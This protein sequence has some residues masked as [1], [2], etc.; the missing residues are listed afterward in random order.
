MSGSDKR[1]DQG[2]RARG[3]STIDGFI[4]DMNFDGQ[5]SKPD[6]VNHTDAAPGTSRGPANESQR[7]DI[8]FGFKAT[9]FIVYPA[10]G[11]GQIIAIDEQTV[12][13]ASLELFVVYFVKSKMT[14]RVPTRKAANVGM[15]KLSDAAAI[16]R[17]RQTLS[18][19]PRK[20]RG[21]WSRLTQ[22]YESKLNSGD[23]I[24]ISEV[25]RDLYRPT[26]NSVQS[27]SER[28]LYTSALDLL[29]G[30][31]ALVNGISEEEAVKDL[32]GLV[33][34]GATRKD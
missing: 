18:Q 15:R 1:T 26:V 13:G 27:Y 7:S 20:G 5:L 8:R 25:M 28:R 31:I 10:H 16:E 29:S 6:Y 3:N 9:D 34:G 14:L 32:E 30:E 22:E 2:G 33:T 4:R 24:A 21:N 12:A 19:A 11:V 23:I 17:V